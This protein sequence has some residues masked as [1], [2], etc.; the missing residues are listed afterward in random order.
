MTNNLI[1]VSNV[2]TSQ[3]ATGGSGITAVT[4]PSVAITSGS[5]I[6]FLTFGGAINNSGSTVNSVALESF[7]TQNFTSGSV[8]SNLIISVTKKWYRNS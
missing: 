4:N 5:R 8:G 7:A 3:S 6:G 1:Q 2:N